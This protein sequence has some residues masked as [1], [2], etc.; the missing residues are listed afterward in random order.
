M[1]SPSASFETCCPVVELRRYTLK[2]RARETLI[3]LFEE[4][5]I[6]SQERTGMRVLGQ[7]R[8]R[9]HP[10]RFVWFRGFSDMEA[11]KRALTDFYFGPVWNEH[12]PAANATMI[13]SDV[14]LL[15]RPL[16]SE[17]GFDWN[18]WRR[19]G[20]DAPDDAADLVAVTIYP[21]SAAASPA[22][23]GAV[24]DE[25]RTAFEEAGANLVAQ[26]VTE[27]SRNTFP[28]LPVREDANVLVWIATYPG[29]VAYRESE[30]RR[31]SSPRWH[32][33]IA[34]GLAALSGGLPEVLLLQPT[35]RSL[36]RHRL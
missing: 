22:L 25:I 24:A 26:L 21:I 19:P 20:M 27:R 35:R 8:D 6:E 3:Q 13:D 7:F 33:R 31:T 2:P 15:L 14:V 4:R 1:S 10:D 11:R 30:A 36:L 17:S 5:F 32:D 9:S 12:G 23:L 34:P 29:D 28:R 18:P 16:D